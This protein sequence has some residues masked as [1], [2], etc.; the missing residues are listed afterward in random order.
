MAEHRVEQIMG[1]PIVIDVRDDIDPAA[2]DEAFTWFRWVDQTFSTYKPQSQIC[3]LDRG[4]LALEDAHPHVREVVARCEELRAETN[5]YF[6]IYVTGH[7]DP[8]G[9]VKGWSV[10]RAG[11]LLERAGAHRF[12]INAGGDILAR[13][14]TPDPWRIGIQ[15]PHRRDRLAYVVEITDGALATSGAYERGAHVLNPHTNGPPTGVLLV[16]LIGSDL[17]STDAYATA[18]FAMG[19]DGPA[20][21]ASL[22]N[23]EAMTILDDHR[24][25]STPGFNAPRMQKARQSGGGPSATT[26][27]RH[28]LE[29]LTSL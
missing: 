22:H 21:T 9:Y 4:E 11:E 14:G 27:K 17:V 8:S 3:R 15:H 16:T 23:H 28:T 5:G 24:V 10:D 25:V 6:D 20:W 1:M 19:R 13:G 29:R 7:L 12:H 2:I 18:A 26:E